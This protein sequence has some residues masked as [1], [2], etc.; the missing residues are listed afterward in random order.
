[1]PPVDPLQPNAE[2]TAVRAEDLLNETVEASGIRPRLSECLH[3]GSPGDEFVL[4]G[5]AR[6]GSTVGFEE[7]ALVALP[8]LSR[9]VVDPPF[10]IQVGILRRTDVR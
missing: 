5:R 10:P 4:R 7:D 3:C 2:V 9:N 6:D 1:M 8:A